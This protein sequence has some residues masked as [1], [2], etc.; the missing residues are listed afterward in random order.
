[1]S[2]FVGSLVSLVIAV[3][4]GYGVMTMVQASRQAGHAYAQCLN[5]HA[6]DHDY[7]ACKSPF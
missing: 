3:T 5:S 2:Q 6:A 1:M 4:I 7:G